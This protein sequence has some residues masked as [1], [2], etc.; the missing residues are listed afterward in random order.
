MIPR[1][2]VSGA[3]I[4]PSVR[5]RVDPSPEHA[6]ARKHEPVRA[7]IVDNGQLQILVEWRAGDGLPHGARATPTR[8]L[9][10]DPSQ[11]EVY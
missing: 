1:S 5:L 6:A 9:R 8:R 7:V 10:F 4:N 11:S 3:H 2:P